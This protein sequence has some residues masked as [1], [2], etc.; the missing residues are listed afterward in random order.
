MRQCDFCDEIAG[1]TCNSF[2]RRYGSTADRI[3]F[4]TA[5]ICVVPTLGQI[6]EGHLLIIPVQH[7]NSIADMDE[8]ATQEFTSVYEEVKQTLR[9]S[10]QDC[11]C[12]E[13]GVRIPGSGGCGIDHAHMHAIPVSGHG[14]LDILQRTFVGSQ[15]GC[16]ADVTHAFSRDVSYLYFESN[17]GERQVF[18]T[19]F[20]PSQYMRR[21]VSESLGKRHWDWRTADFEPGLIATVQKLSVEFS[22][23]IAVTGR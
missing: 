17:E 8:D 23:S 20:I 21:L 9:R 19:P 15:V 18:E 2:S 16:V 11:I 5:R 12:F 6:A 22:L 13:H 10:Y 3:I 14:V 1:G 7:V 4:R